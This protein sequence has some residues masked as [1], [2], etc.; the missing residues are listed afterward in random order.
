M[1]F[2]AFILVLF[3]QTSYGQT[4]FVNYDGPGRVILNYG[5][6]IIGF[7]N[8]SI[9]RPGV[10]H[11]K[12][13]KTK[14]TKKYNDSEVKE[15]FV[16]DL[17][18]YSIRRKDN[19]FAFAQLINNV[20]SKVRFYKYEKQSPVSVGGDYSVTRNVFLWPK[21]AES[22]VNPNDVTFLPHDKNIIK[23]VESCPALAEKIKNKEKGYKF[24][25]MSQDPDRARFEAYSRIFAEFDE[26]K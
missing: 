23:M 8:Y 13:D 24:P 3:A 26:C 22:A 12:S 19:S 20:D 15:F 14:E 6:T 2:G 25:F 1:L 16:N 9:A 5:D 11:I 7:V 21:D 4:G 10:L 17:H 18:Y